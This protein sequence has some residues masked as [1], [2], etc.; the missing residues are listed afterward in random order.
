MNTR[1]TKKEFLHLIISMIND[2]IGD[3]KQ[4]EECDQ[5]EWAYF[6]AELRSKGVSSVARKLDEGVTSKTKMVSRDVS[7]IIKK[8][9]DTKITL[10]G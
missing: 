3:P 4:F 1:L 8:D 10:I 9:G 2:G 7:R 6:L 5:A